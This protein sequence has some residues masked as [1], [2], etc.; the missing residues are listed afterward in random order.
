MKIKDLVKGTYYIRTD[1]AV[2]YMAKLSKLDD[3]M[4]TVL[5]SKT[6]HKPNNTYVEDKLDVIPLNKIKEIRLIE[7][8]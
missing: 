1:N 6:I 2:Y 5:Y 7:A 8:I 4:M 3:I